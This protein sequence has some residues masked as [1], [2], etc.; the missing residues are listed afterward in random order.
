M[1]A[2]QKRIKTFLCNQFDKQSL[3]NLIAKI[4]FDI[5]VVIDD[6]SHIH[7]HQVFTCRTLMPMLKKDVVYIIED[8]QYS[9]TV[10]RRLSNFKL[11]LKEFPILPKHINP[12]HND[13][14]LI[15]KNR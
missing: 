13:K 8:V 10:Q 3:I 6:G 7:Q 12:I 2:D 1:S 15:V 5:D 14:L 4:G 9:N 11:R